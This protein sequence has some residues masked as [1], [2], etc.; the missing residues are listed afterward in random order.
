M[1]SRVMLQCAALATLMLVAGRAPALTAQSE[2]LVDI[3]NLTPQELRSSAFVL[4]APQSIQIEAVGGEPRRDRH[5]GT[6]W[7]SGDSDEWHTWPAA[8]W[9]L[10]ASTRE[11]VWDLR[12]ARTERSD[13]GL[14]RFSGSVLLPA[15]VYIAYYGSYPATS[16]SYSGRFDIASLFR[17][18]SRRRDARYSGPYVDDGSFRQF[19]LAIHGAGRPAAAGHVDSAVRTFNASTVISLRPDSPSA[20][21]RSAFSLSRPTDMEVYAIGELRRDGASDYGWIM[22]ADTRRRVWEMEYRHTED[23]GGAHKNRM[24]HDTLHLPAGR[25]VAYFVSD[26]SHHP[27]DWNAV[28]PFDPE[29]WGLSLRVA[30]AAARAGVR[31]IEWEPVPA[32]Q[33]IVS[34]TQIGDDELRSEGFT[35]LRPMDVRV[36]ALGEGADKNGDLEDYTWIV[37]ATSRRRVW[38]MRYEDTEDA[39]GATKNRLFDGTLHLDAGSYVVYYKSDGS[40]SFEKWNDAP[41]A[42]SRYWG[43]SLFPASGSLDTS[44][45]GPFEPGHRNA[46]A[47]LL[48]VRNGR[49]PHM[50]FNLDHAAAVHV[51]AIGEGVDGEMVDYGW[52]E[53]AETGDKVWEMTY[54]ATTNAGGARKNR[55]YDGMIRLPAGRYELRYESDGSHAYGDWNDDPPDDPERWGITLLPDS[56]R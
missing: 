31:P 11:V 5:A 16:A 56:G 13:D 2:S 8:A 12:E 19:A 26:D 23:A 7:S 15:G 33:T 38:S 34:L 29:F 35:L 14:R 25:Y 49:H 4:S 48:R 28:P 39:G 50:L 43:V 53:N 44:A 54:G 22:N 42:E 32:G 9:I 30:N 46:L 6:W 51:I 40:H 37:D 20:T 24:V 36:H 45:I 41:P 27:G 1:S 18:R 21:L 10:N 17:S 52:I 47:E 55:L 3:R